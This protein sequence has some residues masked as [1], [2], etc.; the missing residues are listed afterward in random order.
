MAVAVSVAAAK[1]T[2]QMRLRRSKLEINFNQYFIV[3]RKPTF[4]HA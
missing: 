1:S 2:I 3:P 4:A